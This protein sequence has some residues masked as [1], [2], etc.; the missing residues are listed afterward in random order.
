MARFTAVNV[1]KLRESP[2]HWLGLDA[3][4]LPPAC[5]YHLARFLILR[6]L[7]L[8]YLVAFAIDGAATLPIQPPPAP[9]TPLKTDFAVDNTLANAGAEIYGRCGGCHGPAAISGGM[10][11]DLRASPM[12]TQTETFVRIVRDGT[13]AIRGMP[14]YAELTDRELTALQ[15]F[16]RRQADSALRPKP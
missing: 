4:P 12:V 15:H 13:R 16:I 11:P 8:I 9:A 3:E 6:L 5:R 2:R 14:A 10:A 7:G 1:A